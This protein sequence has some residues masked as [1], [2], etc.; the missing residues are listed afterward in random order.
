MQYFPLSIFK[1]IQLKFFPRRSGSAPRYSLLLSHRAHVIT[2]QRLKE[3]HKLKLKSTVVHA[4]F[5]EHELYQLVFGVPH[6][7]V[8]LA[9]SIPRLTVTLVKI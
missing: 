6:C 1:V 8:D 9:G 4:V 3:W 5:R 2:Y 7:A